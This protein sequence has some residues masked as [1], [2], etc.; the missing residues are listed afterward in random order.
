MEKKIFLGL[1]T[2]ALIALPL[3]TECNGA[4]TTPTQTPT[5]KTSSPADTTSSVR[6]G[7]WWDKSEQQISL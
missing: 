4:E 7:N 2:V 1:M 3:M 6:A 5:T